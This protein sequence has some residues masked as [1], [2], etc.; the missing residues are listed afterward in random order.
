ATFVDANIQINPPTANNPIGTTH[1][2]TGHV[3]VNAGVQNFSNAPD[4]TTIVFTMTGPAT[5]SGPS[6]CTTSGGT[7]SCSIV[8]ASCTAGAALVKAATNVVLGGVNI[9]R[10]SGDGQTGDS[11]SAA[12]LWGDDTA[13]TDI[14]NASGIVATLAAT[15]KPSVTSGTVIHDKV[16]VDR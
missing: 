3:N 16:Y 6:S 8:I 4:G 2:L 14:M 13:R 5:F 10:E 15:G 9:H 1:T 7:G 11:A 12:K